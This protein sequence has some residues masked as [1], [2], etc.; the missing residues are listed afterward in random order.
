MIQ[1]MFDFA[2]A[3]N[4][5]I[6]GL[7]NNETNDRRTEEGGALLQHRN[8]GVEVSDPHRETEQHEYPKRRHALRH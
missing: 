4:M 6:P 3:L 8:G 7:P 2:I 1:I 5:I